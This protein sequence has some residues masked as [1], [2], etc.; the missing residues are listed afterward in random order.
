MRGD[1]EAGVARLGCQ[2]AADFREL[3]RTY[4]QHV[5]ADGDLPFAYCDTLADFLEFVFGITADL[6]VHRLIVKRL[7]RVGFSHNR[8]HVADVTIDLPHSSRRQRSRPRSR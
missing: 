3:M 5:S 1:F 8:W 7:L 2:S 6:A 4:D